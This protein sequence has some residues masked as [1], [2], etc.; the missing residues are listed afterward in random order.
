[1]V[2]RLRTPTAGWRRRNAPTSRPGSRS[3]TPTRGRSSSNSRDGTR[4]TP[5]WG[6]CWTSASWARRCHAAA[7]TSTPSVK[8]SRTSPSCTSATDSRARTGYWSI[9]TRWR[10]TARSPSTGGTRVTT[11]GCWLT[12]CRKTAASNRRCTC[13]TWPPAKDLPDVIE[14]TRYASV[15]W[16]PDSK[17]FYYTRYPAVGSVPKGEENYHRPRLLPRPGQRPGE[18]S[19][20]LRRGPAAEDMPNVDLSPDGRWLVVTEYQGWAKSEVFFRDLTKE[21]AP[22]SCRWWRRSRRSST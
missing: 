15:A 9:R 12:A 19:R 16:L 20:G 5:A 7:T 14:R 1:M 11:E 8:G 22:R 21:R 13:G 6:N 18:G 3:R 4:S 17:G 10:K 2:W